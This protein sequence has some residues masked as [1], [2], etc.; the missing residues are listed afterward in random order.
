MS[1]ADTPSTSAPANI[2]EDSREGKETDARA[3]VI[4]WCVVIACALSIAFIPV[5]QGITAQSWRLLAIFV[6]TIIGSILR[7]VP[8]GAVVLIGVA[9]VALTGAL[10]VE[11][12]LR[13]YADP[14]VWLVLAAFFISRGMIK[15]G[16]GRR[17]ALLFVRTM[18]RHSLGLG[19]A[20]IST[21]MV[22]ASVIPSNG[23]RSGG[24]IFP[25]AKSIA[26]TYDSKP[27]ATA[28]RLGS[29]LTVLLYQCDVI[30]CAMFLTG[31]ASNVLIAKFAREAA[32]VELSYARWLLGA[33]VPGLISLLVIPLLLYRIFPP[34]IKHT[35]RA[36][37]FA[38]EEL[39][40]MGPV[41][42]PEMLMLVVFGLVAALWMTTALHGLNYA[43]V[44]LA[45]ICVLL[46]SG[47]L[48]WSDVLS[49][50]GAW[51]VFIWYGG[52]V[53]MAEAL[54]ETGLT[55]LFATAAASV[56]IGWTWG[57]A[58]MI[59]LLIYFYAHY[60]FASI[61]AHATAM[62]TPFLIVTIAAGAPPVLAVLSLAYLSNLNASL[63]HYG[64]TPA[65]IWFGAN[66]VRQRTWWWLG[67]MV[68]VPN[69][70]IWVAA[71]FVWWKFLGWW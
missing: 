50:R 56:T 35:P 41:R 33:I 37:E 7:P 21:D 40:R 12:A 3:R 70:L 52:L 58:L 28:R 47:V 67:L 23:A 22:L 34:E 10:P 71:G 55:K 11:Q 15:T 6:A 19:Y 4:K 9:M 60:G 62:Y 64:T 36:A 14:I 57:A 44:A 63:T 18:G 24:I 65:P 69:I 53:R 54:G 66:Y 39:R 17:I 59:L 8:S 27:G 26:E 46:L 30:V 5:P 43:V 38:D 32:G 2:E 51:D 68:S 31:Q 45:G 48:D 49:E 29:F 42:L 13:G 25:I 20:L 1:E 61:T 16:L